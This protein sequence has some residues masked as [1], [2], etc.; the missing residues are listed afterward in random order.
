[1]FLFLTNRCA[2]AN[3]YLPFYSFQQCNLSV[4]VNY[5]LQFHYSSSINVKWL[6][7]VLKFVKSNTVCVHF[8]K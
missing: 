3:E 1:M 6:K 8:A 4:C 7:I 5:N 2:V